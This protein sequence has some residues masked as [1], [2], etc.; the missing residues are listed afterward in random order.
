[1][2]VLNQSQATQTTESNKIN[3]PVITTSGG[4]LGWHFY[5][6]EKEKEQEKKPELSKPVSSATQPNT[7][8][9]FSTKWF[10]KNFDEIQNRAIDKPTKDNMRALLYTEH[11]MNDKSEMFAR[12]K[13]F[14]Q[15]IDPLLQEGTRIPMFGAAKN[16]LLL[17]KDEQK[18]SAL[19][20]L[21]NHVGIAFF[22]DASCHYCQAMIPVINL[23][24]INLGFNIRVFAKNA[25]KNYIPKL[26]NTIPVYS[27]DGFSKQFK[28]S[29]WPA[30]VMLNPP[31]DVYVVGQG[32]VDFAE[33]TNRMINVAFEQ[34]ILNEDWYFRVY[35][36]EKGLISPERLASLKG[37]D[38]KD[39]LAL[40]NQAMSMIQNT[41]SEGVKD[42]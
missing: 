13:R 29:Y 39:P 28:I 30:V 37:L 6:D 33:L 25:P 11:I 1:L 23:I 42:E 18:K 31:N 35:P 15:S 19:K 14:Y 8:K 9:P 5:D 32:S 36:E 24:K 10:R 7:V 2:V 17:Y 22:Y 26:L 41:S 40:I 21:S 20:E 27:D 34:D 12:K 4:N 16:A 3:K 38:S